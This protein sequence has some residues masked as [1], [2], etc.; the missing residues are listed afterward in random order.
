M[1]STYTLLPPLEPK[2]RFYYPLEEVRLRCGQ[3]RVL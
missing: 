2:I 3:I 1:C